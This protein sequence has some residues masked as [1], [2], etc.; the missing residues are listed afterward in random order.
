MRAIALDF[1]QLAV[2]VQRT[3]GTKAVIR[4]AAKGGALLGTT[5]VPKAT[6]SELSVSKAG[7]VYPVGRSIYVL[8][9]GQPKLVWK[10]SGTPIGLSIE[11]RR[12]AWAEN[13]K[14]HGRIVVLTLR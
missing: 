13:V 4:Y 12:I 9:S 2:L 1:R 7:I 10:A 5:V 6:A 3:D 14:G 8:G 11:G